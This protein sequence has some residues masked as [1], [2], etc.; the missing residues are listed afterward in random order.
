MK[1]F[2]VLGLLLLAWPCEATTWYVSP[3]E[4]YETFVALHAAGVLGP[5]DII[6]GKNSIFLE[7]V[8]PNMGGNST[9]RITYQNFKVDGENIR[10]Y[11]IRI[12]SGA[13]GDY[14]TY[15]KIT[16]YNTTSDGIQ[17]AGG[18]D[19]LILADLLVYNSGRYGIC[20]EGDNVAVRNS[21]VHSTHNDGINLMATGTVEVDNVYTWDTANTGANLG[22]G[23]SI[24]ECD[25]TTEIRVHHSRFWRWREAKQGIIIGSTT[26]RA[27]VEIDNNEFW[28][29]NKV[30]SGIR[31]ARCGDAHLH[32]NTMYNIGNCF[33]VTENASD[34]IG[35]VLINENLM[36]DYSQKAFKIGIGI[37]ANIYNNTAVNATDAATALGADHNATIDYRNNLLSG[38]LYFIDSKPTTTYKGNFNLYYL[39][40][41]SHSFYHKYITYTTLAAFQTAS[42]QDQNSTDVNPLLTVD[43]HLTADSP[44]RNAGIEIAGIHDLPLPA[45]DIDGHRIMSDNSTT[46]PPAGCSVFRIKPT[47]TAIPNITKGGNLLK[48]PH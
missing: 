42:G 30:G 29:I 48:I 5:G 22:D 18:C 19:N 13:N 11:G 40:G 45:R 12:Y 32:H 41:A 31:L 3:G 35:D 25:N 38:G 16:I 36:Y 27:N 39:V 9:G 47:G 15:K 43:Y 44:C 10:Q 6:D 7:Q 46:F 34:T 28:G 17:L 4:T 1:A 20:T 2:A 33:N 23:L 24:A 26:G 21:E 37:E 8:S 14:H